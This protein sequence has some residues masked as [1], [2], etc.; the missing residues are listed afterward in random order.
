MARAWRIVGNFH[1]VGEVV[2]F[3]EAPNWQ[4]ALRKGALALKRDPK[5]KGRRIT[6][7]AF[8]V[9]E[10]ADIPTAVMA[11]QLPLASEAITAQAGQEEAAPV[12]VGER[13]E[14]ELE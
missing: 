8:T 6:V 13:P 10:I 5:L 2:V 12:P 9:Q 7:G 14:G 3:A 11:E 4:G 1:S